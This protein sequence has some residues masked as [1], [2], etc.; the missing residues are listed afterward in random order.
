MKLYIC[1]RCSYETCHKGTFRRH[2]ERTIICAPLKDS[3][4]DRFVLKEVSVELM[5]DNKERNYP[6]ERCGK[7]CT[8]PQGKYSHKKTCNVS[9]TSSTTQNLMVNVEKATLP[10][11]NNQ[12]VISNNTRTK[13]VPAPNV[14]DKLIDEINLLKKEVSNMNSF[15]R[16]TSDSSSNEGSTKK[17]IAGFIYLIR[18][19]EFKRMNE[20]VYKVGRTINYSKRMSQYPKGSDLLFMSKV[21]DCVQAEKDILQVLRAEFEH[22]VDI[23]AEYFEADEAALVNTIIH[24]LGQIDR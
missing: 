9:P 7:P 3:F 20:P 17:T 24:H 6:C 1:P 2:L 18:E 10:V 16:Q 23:G 14:L 21:P 13:E 11:K 5:K 8:S 19:R 12:D 22:R 4:I 15:H